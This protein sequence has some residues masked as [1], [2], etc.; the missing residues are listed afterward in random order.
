MGKE[1]KS[2]K[3]EIRIEIANCKIKDFYFNEKEKIDVEGRIEDS[4]S[5]KEFILQKAK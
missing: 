5:W 3:N 4:K 1:N 2:M